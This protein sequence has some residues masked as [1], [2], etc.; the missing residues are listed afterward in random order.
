MQ[1]S[2]K[3]R[4]QK[5]IEKRLKSR[6]YASAE[7]VVTAAL[8]SLEQQEQ[9]GDFEPGELDKLVAEGERSLVEEGPLDGDK[10][11]RARLKR[12]ANARKKT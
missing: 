7:D 12:R 4:V 1:L 9:F 2:L 10:A 5:L 8:L 11:Y 3:P 6:K